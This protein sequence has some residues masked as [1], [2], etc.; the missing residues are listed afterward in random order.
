[1]QGR[2]DY[3][4]GALNIISRRYRLYN[5]RRRDRSGVS[6]VI[7]VVLMVAITLFLFAMLT[8]FV[9]D[10]IWVMDDESENSEFIVWLEDTGSG[11]TVHM[12][13]DFGQNIHTDGVKVDIII[14]VTD[15]SPETVTTYDFTDGYTGDVFGVGDE[16]QKNIGVQVVGTRIG[17]KVYEGGTADTIY[18]GDLTVKGASSGFEIRSVI[19]EPHE[20]KRG[21]SFYIN[22]FVK[23]AS[24]DVPEGMTIY[25]VIDAD[26]INE[27]LTFSLEQ[28]CYVSDEVTL[29]GSATLG[30][31]TVDVEC[32]DLSSTV[33]GTGYIRILSAR[34]R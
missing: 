25:A 8:Y 12:L 1:L 17:V 4:T 2:P 24:G 23:D 34:R 27:T 3:H 13:Y 20:V 6:N 10:N 9:M 5:P 33:Y 32:T 22:V 29:S 31:D 30:V 26:T 19:C 11:I 7:G 16:W 14:Q 18:Y 21:E 28:G 15:S